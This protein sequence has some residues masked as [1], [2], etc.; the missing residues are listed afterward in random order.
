MSAATTLLIGTLMFVPVAAPVPADAPPDP[1]GLGYLG[2]YFISDGSANPL[3]ID[4]ADP[5]TPAQKAGLTKGDLIV[6]FGSLEPKTFEELR[7]H[8][9]AYRPGAV[10]EVEVERNGERRAVKVTL[11]M[12]PPDPGRTPY[13]VPDIPHD[14]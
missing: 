6:R 14:K 3:T 5:N 4:R 8:I 9:M 13:P 7:T 11:A 12:R 1:L 2:A 10:V